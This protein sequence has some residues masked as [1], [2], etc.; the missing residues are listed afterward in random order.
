MKKALWI[1]PILCLSVLIV[2]SFSY[3]QQRGQGMGPGYGYQQQEQGD[4]NYCPY[5]GRPLG[6]RGY[7]RG[8]GMMH[9]RGD[10]GP[11]MMGPGWGYPYGSRYQQ[12]GEPLDKKEAKEIV[13]NQLKA[14]GNP[15]LKVGDIEEEENAFIAEIVT[16]KG[17]SLVDKV[18]IN[19]QTGWMRSIY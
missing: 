11:G 1:L 18:A 4:W 12:Q 3:A 10:R 8:P 19:K 7:H 2:F 5:C 16:R 17:D 13:E 15:N 14:R 6:P 9:R